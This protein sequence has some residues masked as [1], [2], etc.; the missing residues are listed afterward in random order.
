M[1]LAT[2]IGLFAGIGVLVGLIMLDGG[3]LP[4]GFK[5]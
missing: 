1:D 5:P 4:N 2:G 3:N